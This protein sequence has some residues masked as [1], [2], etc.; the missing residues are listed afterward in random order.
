MQTVNKRRSG[1][2]DFYV[3]QWVFYK[4]RSHQRGKVRVPPTQFVVCFRASFMIPYCFCFPVSFF[5][6]SGFMSQ[7][8]INKYKGKMFSVRLFFFLLPMYTY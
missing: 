4:R 1:K 7:D 8:K 5:L 6:S 3:N 2:E